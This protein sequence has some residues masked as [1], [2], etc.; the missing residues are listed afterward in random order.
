[1][2]RHEDEPP[3]QVRPR[4]L[5]RPIKHV[6]WKSG[7]DHIAQDDVEIGRHDL[8]HTLGAARHVRHAKIPF[9]QK[10]LQQVRGHRVVFQQQDRVRFRPAQVL[11]HDMRLFLWRNKKLAA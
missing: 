7:H 10:T 1:M 8:L 3:T 4:P 6:T 2:P 9:L 11:R 5:D